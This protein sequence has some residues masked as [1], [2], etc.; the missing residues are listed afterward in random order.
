[1]LKNNKIHSRFL[2]PNNRSVP[3]NVLKRSNGHV[4]VEFKPVVPGKFTKISFF[5]LLSKQYV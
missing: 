3:I 5:N 4:A 1:M 2:D